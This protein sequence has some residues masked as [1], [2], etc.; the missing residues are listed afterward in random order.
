MT[1]YADRPWIKKYDP[2]V[3]RTLEPYPQIALHQLLA[4]A[5][6]E[7]PERTALIT[8][9][10]LP[11]GRRTSEF[12]YGQLDRASSAL[13]AGLAALGLKKGDRVAIIL[14]NVVAFAIAFYGVLKAGGVVAAVNPTYPPP[15][16]A[17]QIADC[18]AEIVITLSLFYKTVKEIQRDTAVK[19]VIVTNVKEY[20]PPLAKFLFTLARE[21]KDGH[22]VEKNLPEGDFWLQDILHQYDGQ[23]VKTLV[24]ADDLAIFQYTGGTTGIP[25]GAMA[26][27]AALIA[28]MVQME[29][30]A[31]PAGINY[32]K[33]TT[34]GALPMFHVYGMVA[35][36]SRCIATG[37]NMVLAPN[38]RDVDE[39]VDIIHVHQPTSFAG[40]PQLFNAIANHPRVQSGEVSLKCINWCSSGSAPLPPTTQQQFGSLISGRVGEGFGMS[41]APTA[42]HTNPLL[43][44]IRVGSI[45]LPFPDV[46]AR[47]VSL[48]DGETD[49]PISEIGEL[50]MAGPNIMV[51][52]HN[53]PGETAS[54]LKEKGGKRWL[55]TGDIAR[56]DED[57][58][59][60]IIDRKKDMALIGGF[61]VYPTQVEKVIKDHPAV[62][63]VGVA[64]IAH[65]EREGQEALKAWIVTQPGTPVTEA[66]IIAHCE[67]FLAPYEVPRR[68]AFVAELPKTAVGKTLRRELVQ[69]EAADRAG[70]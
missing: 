34:L 51:G 55:Y 63:E 8:S 16:M 30:W 24:S 18:G 6:R 35:M 42:T 14:P 39:L 1:T 40:V 5:A 2:G 43:G 31:A 53:M 58:Y 3:P 61:N 15:R 59:F 37:A 66:E 69:M 60:Y 41:E 38:A 56:M 22:Y 52:Y 47:I 20:F 7:Y 25:K 17:H 9:V 13:A 57:G 70:R 33:Q 27:H 44:E 36:L 48:D 19:H 62:L 32:S 50:V 45:G 67:K 26:T 23:T 11:G 64:A 46:D 4:K 10:K 54:V 68:V 12:T 28:N 49:V 21:K 65:P 29:A